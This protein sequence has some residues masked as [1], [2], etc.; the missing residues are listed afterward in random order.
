MRQ[1]MDSESLHRRLSKIIGQIKAIDKMVDEDVPCEDVLIQINAA[2]GAL[3]KVGQIVL[4]GHLNHCVRE[5]IE[6]GNADKTIAD[7]TKAV[8]HFSRMS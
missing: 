4:E 6:H 3:H 2:K 1:C 7:F 5:G 8:E